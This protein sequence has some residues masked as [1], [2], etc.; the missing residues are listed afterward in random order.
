MT[1]ARS[2]RPQE[3]LGQP[4]QRGRIAEY[5]VR[6]RDSVVVDRAWVVDRACQTCAHD[7]PRPR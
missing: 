7:C 4:F 5:I 3:P 1:P 2:R 6:H